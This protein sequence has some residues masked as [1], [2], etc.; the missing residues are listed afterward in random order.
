[1]RVRSVGALVARAD[2]AVDEFVADAGARH[3]KRCPD[4]GELLVLLLV[5]NRRWDDAFSD[6]WVTECFA[7][8]V[9]WWC[10]PL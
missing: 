3:K 7:R 2:A 9:M 8:G 6:A 5:S 1:M 4:L 10:R